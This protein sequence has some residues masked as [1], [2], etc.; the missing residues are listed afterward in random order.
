M[1]LA[2]TG[3]DRCQLRSL[4]IEARRSVPQAWYDT[5]SFALVRRGFLIRQRMDA[6]GRLSAV[7]A[8]GPGGGFPIEAS[9]SADPG[10][11]V[12]TG[13]AVTRQ[14]ICAVEPHP[15]ESALAQGG[16]TARD[17]HL[18]QREALYRMERLADARARATLRSRVA[19]LLCAL[20]DTLVRAA[21]E[22]DWLPA[23]FLQRDLASLLS[24][25]QESLSRT[26]GQFAKQRWIERDA[27]GT[28]LLSRAALE[29]A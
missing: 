4:A 1:Q 14:L 24:I 7:D 19:A 12:S 3:S 5:Y 28:R 21:P 6:Q 22:P 11:S 8:V 27:E 16:D 17:V 25:R 18:L 9:S 29:A 23:S 2:D 20:A 13:Y 10:R 15:V 26:L